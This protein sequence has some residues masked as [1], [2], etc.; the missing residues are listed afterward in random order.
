MLIEKA[1]K[2]RE[3]VVKLHD[4]KEMVKKVEEVLIETVKNFKPCEDFTITQIP[5][6]GD[7]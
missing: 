1:S 2:C 3:T 5:A 7:E 4:E 6:R